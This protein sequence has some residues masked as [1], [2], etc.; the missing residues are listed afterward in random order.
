MI[1][2]VS[3]FVCVLDT[4]AGYA[5]KWLFTKFETLIPFWLPIGRVEK[6]GTGFLIGWKPVGGGNGFLPDV[7]HV[8]IFVLLWTGGSKW[9]G[10]RE[11][12]KRLVTG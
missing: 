10:L 6:P 9:R 2:W 5:A 7:K 4:A 8:G 1:F 12:V 3:G 11:S